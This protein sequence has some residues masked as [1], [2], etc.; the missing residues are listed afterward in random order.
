[1][2]C[3]WARAQKLGWAG[4]SY[5]PNSPLDLLIAGRQAPLRNARG[6]LPIGI[7]S[8]LQTLNL[9]LDILVLGLY[10]PN[11]ELGRFQ[12]A[13]WFQ[14]GAYLL[15]SLVMTVLFPRISRLLRSPSLRARAYVRSLLKNG[16]V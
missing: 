10:A 7:T 4:E 9:R 8:I 15:A 11:H 12:A 6:S 2:R 3:S 16:I 13:A 14:V 5:S 1:V